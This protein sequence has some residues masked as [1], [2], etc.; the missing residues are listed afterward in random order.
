MIKKVKT[1]KDYKTIIH[2]IEIEKGKYMLNG[3]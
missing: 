1:A 3:L 2:V